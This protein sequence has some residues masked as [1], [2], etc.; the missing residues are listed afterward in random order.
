M[1]YVFLMTQMSIWCEPNQEVKDYRGRLEERV[2]G[3][4]L[5]PAEII[6]KT[7]L[8]KTLY[9]HHMLNTT[10]NKNPDFETVH[11][12]LPNRKNRRQ[13]TE[14]FLNGFAIQARP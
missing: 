14:S 12:L 7:C 10:G 13:I 6:T 2:P 1:P 5:R 11:S 8:E 9:D 4:H 3:T